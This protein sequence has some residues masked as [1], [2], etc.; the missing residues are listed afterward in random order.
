[1]DKLKIKWWPQPRQEHFLSLAGLWPPENPPE[2]SADEILYGG[3]AGGGKT[4]ALLIAGM[5]YALKYPGCQIAYFR[6][7]FPELEAPEGPVDRSQ[8]LFYPVAQYWKGARQWKFVTGSSL[9]FM[10]LAEE[11]DKQRHRGDQIDLLIFDELTLF[12][13]SMFEFLRSRNRSTVAGSKPMT[14]AG[15]NPGGIGHA[16]VRARFVDASEQGKKVILTPEG[17]KRLFVPAKLADNQAL[18][19]RDPNYRKRLMALPEAERKALLEGL[20]DVY[21]GQFFGEWSDYHVVEPFT[22]PED[23][24][25]IG[26]YD[27]GY[28]KPSVYSLYALNP[29][30][31]AYKIAEHVTV[32]WEEGIPV[33]APA[34]I[35]EQI[36]QVKALEKEWGKPHYRV[37]DPAIWQKNG[38]TGESIAE[39]FNRA[40]LHFQQ[41][42]NERI[43][44]W[45]RLREWFKIQ[46]G[47]DGKPTP[48]LRYFRHC[49]Y[50]TW[51]IPTLI[52]DPSKP[53]DLDTD[54]E[55]HA[56]DTDRYFVM[57]RPE[58]RT[59]GSFLAGDFP[60]RRTKRGDD[61]DDDGPRAPSFY[62]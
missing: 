15:T 11:E 58:P 24:T 13:K 59:G 28:P 54:G 32:R 38:Q 47:L 50:S 36:E 27:F 43:N 17:E 61:D 9:K 55:D 40:G 35:S 45:M 57:S 10:H 30:G 19:Q 23:W 2:P 33:Q 51:S 41:A 49:R 26:S 8:D 53:G 7:T 42:K 37:A 21:A 6:R 22:I 44:G 46:P 62:G 5:I 48:L 60:G 56:A 20:W 14:L 25:R 4:D 34:L 31:G 12:T 52:H 3:A 16:W 1:M 18:E 39:S 29:A